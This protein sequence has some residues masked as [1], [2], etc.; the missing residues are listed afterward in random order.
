MD[1]PR[2]FYITTTKIYE[3]AIIEKNKYG[4]QIGKAKLQNDAK[5]YRG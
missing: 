5:Y 4:R 1:W 3:L 2:S